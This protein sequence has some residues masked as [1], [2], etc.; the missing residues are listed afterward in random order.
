MHRLLVETEQLE[1]R[2]PALSV[3]ARRHLRVVRPK[4]G[5]EVELFDGRGSWRVFACR[6]PGGSPD[7]SLAPVSEVRTLARPPVSISLFACVTKG[8]RWDWTIEKATELGVSRIVP[9]VSERTIVRL[10]PGDGEAKRERWMRVAEEAARQSDAK[11]LPEILPPV[12]FAESLPL[13]RA[14][15][16]FVGALADPPPPHVG[17]ALAEARASAAADWAVYVGPEGDFSPAELAALME[18]ATPVSFG[19]TVLRAETAAIYGVSA[20]K[21][22][23]D[24]WYNLRPSNQTRPSRG[25]SKE[26]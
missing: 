16:C 1:S 13:V 7:V 9:V 6:R 4:D 23:L 5:E 12:T 20:L 26:Q 3:D 17:E 18:C 25:N 14:T 19:P 15:T 21:T 11:W 22:F 24:I 10:A 8:S 2:A